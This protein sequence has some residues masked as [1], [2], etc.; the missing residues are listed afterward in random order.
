MKWETLA[1]LGLFAFPIAARAQNSTRYPAATSN[2]LIIGHRAVKSPEVIE[3]LGIPYA[4]PPVNDLR[5]APPQKLG[6]Q[7]TYVAANYVSVPCH[8]DISCLIIS[9]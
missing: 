7:G 3:Y 4:Q 5:F 1:L 9:K 8:I 2:G 6:K